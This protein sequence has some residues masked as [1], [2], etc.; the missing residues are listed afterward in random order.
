MSVINTKG[1]ELTLV[2]SIAQGNDII[3]TEEPFWRIDNPWVWIIGIGVAI[4]LFRK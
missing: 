3:T 4:L 2:Q 1:T